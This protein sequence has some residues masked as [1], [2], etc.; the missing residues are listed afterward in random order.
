MAAAIALP[1]GQ[2]GGPPAPEKTQAPI[3]GTSARTQTPG[4][5]SRP[6]VGR[7][8]QPKLGAELVRQL[9]LRQ[10]QPELVGALQRPESGQRPDQ[11]LL[12]DLHSGCVQVGNP[13]GYCVKFTS[14]NAVRQCLGL[15]GTPG[16]LNCSAV[17]P[18]SCSAG[19]FCAQV[20]ALQLNCDFGDAGA[21]SG[22]G[23]PCGDLGLQRFHLS[24]QRPEGARH[25]ARRPIASWVAAAPH[26]AA[27]PVTSAV[28]AVISTNASKAARSAVGAKAILPCL[29]SAAL[30]F[31]HR[32]GDR[33]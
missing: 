6:M 14:C 4:Q 27:P 23:G 19:S 18:S 20:L 25:S 15:T 12:H 29:Y 32:C 13:N 21:G 7:F 31:R 2:T 3:A 10:S 22:F 11:L 8:L 26:P 9:E 17:N 24:L 28:F 16:A 5:Q 1:P 33:Q 30:R